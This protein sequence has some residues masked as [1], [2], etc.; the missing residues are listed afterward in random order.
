MDS[1]TQPAHAYDTTRYFGNTYVEYVGIEFYTAAVTIPETGR[2]AGDFVGDHLSNTWYDPEGEWNRVQEGVN[3]TWQGTIALGTQI[4]NDPW[5]SLQSAGSATVNYV[6]QVLKDPTVSG[7]LL[8]DGAVAWA[9][10]GASAVGKK[11]VFETVDALWDL[12]KNLRKVPDAGHAKPVTGT[13]ETPSF[14]IPQGNTTVY[15]SIDELGNVQYIGITDDLERRA[16]EHLRE[17]GI[18]IDAIPGLLGIDRDAARAVEQVLIEAFGLSKNG[19][20]LLNRIN[21]IATINPIYDDAVILGR[22]IL[23]AIGFPGF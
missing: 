16:A 8:G 19:G 13:P 6:D 7:K 17:K 3:A 23:G 4:Y 11:V 21:S 10:G 15:Q 20:T 22:N 2:A 12:G 1:A 5:G 9:T 14:E 18:E